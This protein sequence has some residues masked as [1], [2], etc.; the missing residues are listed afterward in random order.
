M[1]RRAILAYHLHNIR[2]FGILSNTRH[3]ISIKI[4]Y[5]GFV[6]EHARTWAKKEKKNILIEGW[7][8]LQTAS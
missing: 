4:N 6:N 7:S 2:H 8:Y 1:K 3:L 5:V